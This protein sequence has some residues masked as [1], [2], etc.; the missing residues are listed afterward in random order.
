[1]VVVAVIVVVLVVGVEVDMMEVDF[2]EVDM[3]VVD[4]VITNPFLLEI[5]S[6]I[7]FWILPCFASTSLCFFLLAS[8]QD[9]SQDLTND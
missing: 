2:V 5:Y 3:V 9:S 6:S 7:L 4:L 8:S 1:M